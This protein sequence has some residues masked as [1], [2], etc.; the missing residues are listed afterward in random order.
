MANPRQPSPLELRRAFREVYRQVRM[1]LYCAIRKAAEALPEVPSEDELLSSVQLLLYRMLFIHSCEDRAEPLIPRGTWE[2]SIQAALRLPG[3][4]EYKV[5]DQLKAL[6]R[7]IDSGSPPYSGPREAGYRGDLFKPHPILDSIHLPDSLA[8]KLHFQ[9]QLSEHLL[10]HL[11][12]ESLAGRRQK[13]VYYTLELISDFLAS[14]A[15]QALLRERQSCLQSL[16]VADL[17]CG[18]GAFLLSAYNV[19]LR[20]HGGAC[21]EG[22]R[23]LYGVDLLPEAVELARLALWLR[24]AQRGERGADLGDNLLCADS[25]GGGDLFHR[26]GVK[27]GSFDLVLGNPPWGAELTPAQV[28]EACK[29]LDLD[30]RRKWDSWELFVALSLHALREG[31]RLALVLPDTLFSPEKSEIR[32][33]L[34]EQTQIEKLHN[35]GADWFGVQ[36][37]MGAVVLQARKGTPPA[38]SDMESLLLSG[39]LRRRAIAG[40]VPLTHIEARYS[41]KVPQE[42][43][44]AS[45]TFEIEVFRSREDDRLIRSMEARSQELAAVCER[46]RGEEM[47]KSGLLWRCLGCMGLTT[48]GE[49]RRGGLFHDKNCP[50]CGYLLSSSNIQPYYMVTE[51]SREGASCPFID[52]DLVA[53]RYARLKPTKRLRLGVEGWPYKDPA[54]YKGPKI[55]LRQAGVGVA[56]TLDATNA[57]CPQSVYIYRV[58]PEFSAAGLSNEYVLA[59]LVSRAMAFYVFKRFGEVDPARAHAK[60]T[61]ERLAT[62]P[63]PVIDL[64]QKAGQRIHEE[65]ILNVRKL[66]CGEARLGGP[67]DWRIELLLRELWGL[68]AED[69]RYMNSELAQVP[70]SQSLRDLFPEGRAALD[71]V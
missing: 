38:S 65:I 39:E 8:R 59:A 25:L 1:D 14:G 12:E 42:R 20:E 32:R 66:L 10:G 50:Q 22:L 46:G 62:L 17:A 58:R 13:G 2:G 64:Q 19:L 57:R 41:R 35:L 53:G 3:S 29:A 71:R 23:C 26:L 11:F 16:K 45:P 30:P 24:S 33:I 69:G 49:K 21:L 56:A 7:G 37:R 18:A 5:Y 27:P 54:T 63:I 70:E 67:E 4:C 36:V 61:H 60:L 44:R 51:D 40:E 47:S 28:Q 43:C 52:G 6:F 68:T 34:L 15:L 48:P 9:G 55:V 31:G